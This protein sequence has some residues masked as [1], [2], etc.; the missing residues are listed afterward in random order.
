MS[1]VGVCTLIKARC[2]NVWRVC[3]CPCVQLHTWVYF[4]TPHFPLHPFYE[5]KAEITEHTDELQYLIV[6]LFTLSRL[7]WTVG[8]YVLGASI[9]KREGW[10]SCWAVRRE[11]SGGAILNPVQSALISTST[12][13]ACTG[14]TPSL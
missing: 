6:R 2:L 13:L 4:C 8:Y 11:C 7:M 3:T 9:K 1:L 14:G 12:S 5:W 10:L